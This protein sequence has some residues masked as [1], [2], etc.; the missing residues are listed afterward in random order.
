MNYPTDPIS[1]ILLEK[2][3]EY[4]LNNVLNND[5]MFTNTI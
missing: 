3:V 1:T 5:N 4:M 2:G